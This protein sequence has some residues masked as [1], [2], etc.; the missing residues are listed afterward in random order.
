MKFGY[1]TRLIVLLAAPLL[2]KVRFRHLREICVISFIYVVIGKMFVA[3][4]SGIPYCMQSCRCHIHESCVVVGTAGSV[5]PVVV[6]HVHTLLG[7][8]VGRAMSENDDSGAA[9]KRV[10]KEPGPNWSAQEVNALIEAKRKC[11]GK[12]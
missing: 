5:R 12:E 3:H 9:H 4:L 10:C 8:T 2:V 11:H 7:I 1:Q 6:G